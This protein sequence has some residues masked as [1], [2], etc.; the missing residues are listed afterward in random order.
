MVKENRTRNVQVKFRLTPTEKSALDIDVKNSGLTLNDYLI[1][2]LINKIGFPAITC[3]RKYG[4]NSI[5][6]S[7]MLGSQRI[8][9]ASSLFFE[10]TK[11]VQISGFYVIKPFQDFGIEERLMHEIY[12]YANI[13]G[14]ER[15][16]A[17]PGAEPYCPTEWKTLDVQ[18][19]WY[20]SQ[21]FYVDHIVNGATPCMVKP[22]YLRII[23]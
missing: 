20:K 10:N 1:R 5:D 18:E 7:F 11:T 9:F 22:L 4:N 16:V 12:D 3:E 19:K 17:Y 6:V 2:T 8:G 13:N 14:A 21:G 15:I 23:S